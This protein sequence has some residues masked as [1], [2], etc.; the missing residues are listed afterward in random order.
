MTVDARTR[1]SSS[2][3]RLDRLVR[4]DEPAT[5]CAAVSGRLLGVVATLEPDARITLTMSARR[6]GAVT[7]LLHAS[8]VGP[9][10]GDDLAWCCRRIH[11][12][13]EES[14]PPQI[15]RPARLYEIVAATEERERWPV[16]ADAAPGPA[17]DP[18]ASGDLATLDPPPTAPRGMWPAYLP[19]SGMMLLEA[20][21]DT[22]GVLRL[23]LAPAG[24]V[25]ARMLEDVVSRAEGWSDVAALERIGT[26]VRMRA[27]VGGAPGD[28]RLPGRLAVALHA[29]ANG[30]LIRPAAQDPERL[31]EGDADLLRGRAVPEAMAAALTRLPIAGPKTVVMGVRCVQ[32]V[33]SDVPLADETPETPEALEASETPKVPEA[34]ARGLRLGTAITPEGGRSPVRIAPG[35]LTRHVHVVGATGTGK[36]TLLRAVGHGVLSA[37]A[38]GAVGGRGAAGTGGGMMVL[39]PHGSTVNAII[40][41]APEEALGRITLVRLDDTDHPVRLN[42]FRRRDAEKVLE[43]VM[44]VLYEIFD[45]RHEGIIGPR[46]ERIFRQI[47]AAQRALLGDDATLTLVPAMLADRDSLQGLTRALAKT[48]PVLAREIR[49]ELADNR[50]SDFSDILAWVSCKFDRLVR[51]RVMREVF[52]SG[53]ETLDVA[54]IIDTG[55]I[56]LVDLA[57]PAVGEDTSR[58]VAM[59]LLMEAEMALTSRRRTGRG[60]RG[61]HPGRG[62]AGRPEAECDPFLVVVDEVQRV[63][64]DSLSRLLAEGRK[65]GAGVVLAHQHLGQLSPSMLGALEANAA[66]LL[67]FRSSGVDAARAH[68]RLGTWT[69]GPLTRLPS[70]RAA[71]TL[72][73]PH[74]QT[75][76]FTLQVDH[77]ERVAALIDDDEAC[78]RIDAV[79]AARV[80]WNGFDRARPL[81]AE[82]LEKARKRLLQRASDGPAEEDKKGSGSSSS[83]TS[84]LDEWL[85]NRRAS[86]ADGSASTAS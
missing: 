16:R 56:L 71:T 33:L 42:P 53:R 67:A 28:R 66:T 37:A 20:L 13:A 35:L 84:F 18:C 49:T 45:P 3:Y 52:G 14:D 7:I 50:S 46:F 21:R 47:M 19:G 54:G 82:D 75:Q 4:A 8:G 27:L 59:T 29:A 25:E 1:A 40:A 5:V 39:D 83:G 41:E 57:T 44:S 68:D 6:L 30:L 17:P 23:H 62:P 9:E 15:P 2:C 12:W 78:D 38:A 31:W 51:S 70:L 63:Q 26:P 11:V 76:A 58:F 43:D 86:G 60:A 55:G 77:N 61:R 81:N 74:G 65:F 73:S 10:F 22:G 79:E 85:A 24:P 64:C 80:R 69:G 34:P 48:D 36:S 32:P 72:A